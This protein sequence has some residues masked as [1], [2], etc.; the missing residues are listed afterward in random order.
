MPSIACG[1][2]SA[3]RARAVRAEKHG[4][5]DHHQK[6]TPRRRAAQH[7]HAGQQCQCAG[8]VPRGEAPARTAIG[9]PPSANATHTSR[10]RRTRPATTD[11]SSRSACFSSW[12]A[13]AQASVVPNHHA[14]AARRRPDAAS[15]WPAP[16]I[17]QPGRRHA[18]RRR[19]ANAPAMG[20]RSSRRR[21]GSATD[22]GRSC[23]RP[24]RHTRPSRA[25]QRHAAR[26]GSSAGILANH[27]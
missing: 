14:A 16:A 21:N 15:R 11:S 6:P 22:R 13:M 4:T 3:R 27:A 18:A 23:P 1:S 10:S 26:K 2:R 9:H 12:I 19:R 24:P 5:R 25:G 17:R 8:R 20:S 7:V